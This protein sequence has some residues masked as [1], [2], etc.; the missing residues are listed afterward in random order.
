MSREQSA[1]VD[2]AW[3]AIDRDALAELLGQMV[4]TASPPGEEAQLAALLADELR[5]AGLNAATQPLRGRQA[6]A[7]GRLEGSGTGPD[8]L[9]Y[10]AI[11]TAFTGTE[12]EDMPWLGETRR[13]D[14]IP[15]ARQEGEWIIGL[16][17]ENPK[18]FAACVIEAARAISRAGIPLNGSLLVG[19]GA[20]GMPTNRLP[21]IADGPP[22]GHGVGCTHMLES[23]FKGDFAVTCKPGYAVAW[24]EVGISWWQIRIRGKLG[25]TGVRHLIPY[26]NAIV[27]AALVVRALEDWF[28]EFTARFSSGLVAPQGAVGSIAGGWPYKPAFTPAAC[29]VWVDLRVSPRASIEEVGSALEDLLGRLRTQDPELSLDS[30]CMLAIPGSHTDP[31]NWIIRSAIRAWEAVESC[32]HAPIVG[33][34]GA[35][36]AAILR[37]HGLPTARLGMPRP[38]TPPPFGGFSMGQAN[39]QSMLALVRC[40]VWTVI[41]T[42][43]RSRSE[44]G[45]D[46]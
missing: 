26:R 37:A 41:D 12:S 21:T 30:E 23:G 46:G 2:Q 1:W 9:L 25:Y 35:T 22:I 31:D 3:S 5:R 40:L 17:A 44:V 14:F 20:G 39:T 19:L 42:C 28:P 15:T 33:T 10:S 38:A 45:I 32:A 4:S 11:D 43:S 27:D 24:E 16:G 36:D 13:A 8:L 34:S 7:I 29:D 6:N 18:G